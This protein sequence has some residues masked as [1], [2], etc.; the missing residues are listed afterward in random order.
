VTTAKGY[1]WV[2]NVGPGRDKESRERTGRGSKGSMSSG[3]G[4]GPRLYEEP[5]WA[6]AGR[7]RG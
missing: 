1:I 7:R 5:E 4:A 3:V 6:A 2:W